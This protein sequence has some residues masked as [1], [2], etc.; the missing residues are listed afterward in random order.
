MRLAIH[1]LLLP[2][3]VNGVQ[4]VIRLWPCMQ[5]VFRGSPPFLKIA[6]YQQHLWSLQINTRSS[7][8]SR[9]QGHADPGAGSRESGP[10]VFLNA[11]ALLPN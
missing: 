4:V 6:M 5:G 3:S 8:C 7:V 10:P 1:I 2:N 9:H 11:N